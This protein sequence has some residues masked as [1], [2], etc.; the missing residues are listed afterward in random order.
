MEESASRSAQW[1]RFHLRYDHPERG[2]RRIHYDFL[3]PG[4]EHYQSIIH[5]F[6]DNLTY[7]I[8]HSVG[9]CKITRGTES[10]DVN[11]IVDPIGFFI[12]NERQFIYRERERIWEFNGYRRKEHFITQ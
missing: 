2:P 11:P 12:K 4:S 8:D 9:T 3:P 5:D 7:T 10:P 1:Q 6:G